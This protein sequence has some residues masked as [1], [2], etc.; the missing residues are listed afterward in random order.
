MT[1]VAI[2]IFDGLHPTNDIRDTALISEVLQ[3]AEM[4]HAATMDANGH[5]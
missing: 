1:S 4:C 5:P 2:V 3:S